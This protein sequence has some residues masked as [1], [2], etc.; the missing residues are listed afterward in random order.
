VYVSVETMMSTRLVC[1]AGMRLGVVT[2]TNVMRLLLPN[3]SSANCRA[4]S[5]S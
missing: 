1:S 5:T 3:A 4:T 2:Q